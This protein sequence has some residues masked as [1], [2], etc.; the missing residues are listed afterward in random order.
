VGEDKS[1]KC[2]EREKT[3]ATNER[4]KMRV[5]ERENSSMRRRTM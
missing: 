5:S 4:E 2:S 1:N 3:R